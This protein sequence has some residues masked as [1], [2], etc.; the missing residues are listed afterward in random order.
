VSGEDR[1]AAQALPPQVALYHLAI[2]HYLSRALHLAAVLGI[3]D[4]L[5]DGPRPAGALARATA[6]HEPSLHRVLRLLAS[7]GVLDEREDGTFALTPIGE[8]LRTDVPGSAHAMVKL[9]AG[10]RIQDNW[11]DLEHCVRTGEPAFRKR[12][13]TDPFEDSLWDPEEE[14]TFDAAMANFTRMTAVAVAAA[15]DVSSFETIVDVGGGN[16]ALLIG[17]LQAASGPRGI[18]FD[19]AAAA[20]RAVTAIAASGLSE[21]CRAVTGDFFKEVPRGGD[22][23]VLKHVIHDW[24]DER[25]TAILRN[26][27]R[28]M[29]AGGTLLIVEGVYPPRID[30][31]LAGRGA[32]A[33]DVNMLVNTG[34]RQ[35]SEAEF[36]TLYDAAGFTLTRI[37]P[38]PARVAVIEGRPAG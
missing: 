20:E 1:L 8:C 21:R 23:Y 2:G 22:A 38:T 14:A 16:G 33:N 34:G 5:K 30:Q 37:V 29:T 6:T 4:M 35:R 27:R 28:A 9:F 31:S 26:C 7:Q 19:R 32:A 24:D 15:Y 36:R 12:G 10:P 13:A 17:L 18:V 3:A 25:A 11:K